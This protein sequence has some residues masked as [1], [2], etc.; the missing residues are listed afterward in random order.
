M[1]KFSVQGA[2]TEFLLIDKLVFCLYLSNQKFD[3]KFL[4]FLHKV[5]RKTH[6]TPPH[7][8]H[9]HF[10]STKSFSLLFY[11]KIFQKYS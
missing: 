1:F 7:P 8:N 6:I 2:T 10:S 5:T 4:S 3:I 11:C 9:T